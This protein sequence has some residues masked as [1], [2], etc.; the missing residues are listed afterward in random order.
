MDHSIDPQLLF[1]QSV[2]LR[3]LAAQ[4]VCD[5]HQREDALQE[6]WL[7]TLE[8]PPEA[9]DVP[10]LRIWL[11]RVLRY[12]VLH[13]RRGVSRRA[14]REQAVA[15]DV[16]T[17]SAA[18]PLE[19]AELHR[20]LMDAVLSL[21]PAQR[22]LILLRF[23]DD[24]PPREIAVRLGLGGAVVRSRLSRALQSL[25]EK[26]DGG[27]DGD[28]RAWSLAFL[29]QII[30][31]GGNLS[32]GAVVMKTQTKIVLTLLL[33]VSVLATVGGLAMNGDSGETAALE[34]LDTPT[35]NGL[36]GPA[37]ENAPAD[38]AM[39]GEL[40]PTRAS[41]T[42]E[43]AFAAR[44]TLEIE[45]S[46]NDVAGDPVPEIL[47]RFETWESP[48]TGYKPLGEPWTATTDEHGVFRMP[49]P[50][51][52][53]RLRISSEEWVVLLDEYLEQV[54]PTRELQLFVAPRCDYAGWVTDEQGRSV[55]GC[56]LMV[57][58][59]SGLLAGLR[60]GVQRM[61]SPWWNTTSDDEGH[62][63]LPSIGWTEGL[64][65]RAK[66]V[67]FQDHELPLPDS[68]K[69]DLAVTLSRSLASSGELSGLVLDTAGL[70]VSGAWVYLGEAV[71]RCGAQGDFIIPWDG[72]AGELMALGRGFLPG[73]L[74]LTAG[75]GGS[76]VVLL[77]TPTL[78]IR[79]RVIDDL[80]QNLVGA[81]VWTWD[82]SPLPPVERPLRPRTIEEAIG[83][84][85]GEVETD[86]EGRFELDDRLPRA[87]MMH[88]MHPET[89]EV[90]SAEVEAGSEYT[91]VLSGQEPLRR[92]AGRVLSFSGVPV[93]GVR[94]IY[95]R[96][97]IGEHPDR[98][99]PY[100][101]ERARQADSE[102]RFE[103]ETLVVQDTFFTVSG[104]DVSLWHYVLDES[105]DLENLEIR[106]P[107]RCDVQV[108]LEEDPEEADGVYLLDE[109]GEPVKWCIFHGTVD[110]RAGVAS[111]FSGGPGPASI[112]DGKTEVLLTD[113]R[114]RTVVLMKD[115][116]EVRRVSVQL[117]PGKVE[118]LRM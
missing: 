65:L 105:E 11:A 77:D 46:V 117:T 100:N 15:R 51:T 89:L 94:L 99:S 98:R 53:G 79:G 33:L 92:V 32:R 78:T 59:P 80:G 1:E 37:N 73:R 116:E 10:S 74:E 7:T 87:Y 45:G 118:L 93:A 24:L 9:R 38:L 102:G 96:R 60:P 43:L 88:A 8:D 75:A 28:R 108:L 111:F 112:R 103:F 18:E 61:S 67:G 14:R 69:S 76:A 30:E 2:W 20:E 35:T 68:D 5:P 6:T 115:G 17:P 71:V 50:G 72:A 97:G 85:R 16:S 64:L 27:R 110:D 107:L 54:P 4:L 39:A 109:A 49:F 29:T 62:F 66:T 114:V 47:V 56:V 113:E 36:P 25:R 91:F 86:S 48:H 21:G 81:P 23:L 106:V 101:Y 44:D 57:Q 83:Y 19:R 31:S 52:V 95:G 104:A 40:D 82:G 84:S 42:S 26:L 90:V 58:I 70:G 3:R 22:D 13:E 12:K 55:S 63:D 34:G 41:A